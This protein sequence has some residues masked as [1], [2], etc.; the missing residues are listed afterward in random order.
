MFY[1]KS[2][3]WQPVHYIHVL[4][5]NTVHVS[6]QFFCYGCNEGLIDGINSF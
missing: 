2:V 6:T 4:L 5:W 3:K 1:K